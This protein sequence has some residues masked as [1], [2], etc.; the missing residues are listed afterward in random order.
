MATNSSSVRSCAAL[1]LIRAAGVPVAAPSANISGF[2]S[3]TAAQYVIDDM[4][5]RIAAILDG[6]ECE[7]G[8]ESTVVTLATNPPEL[9]RPGAVKTDML[10][11]S[12]DRLRSFCENTKLYPVNAGRFRRIVERVEARSVPPE[13]IAAVIGRALTCRRPRLVY[14]VNRNPLLLLFSALPPIGLM[15]SAYTGT[16]SN[17]V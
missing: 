16:P 7:V 1:A 6:G 17:L 13:K 5:G 14:Y 12:T 10:T 11:V 8:I 15:Y 3:P 4:N 2:P 9:L